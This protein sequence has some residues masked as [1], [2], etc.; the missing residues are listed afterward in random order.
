VILLEGKKVV[1]KKEEKLK[2]ISNEYVNKYN[3]RPCL[4][5]FSSTDN[6]ASLAYVNRIEK[7]CAKFNIDVIKYKY[8]NFEKFKKE[9]DF[10]NS[11]KNVTAIMFQEPLLDEL[12]CFVERI[13][14][15]KDVEGITFKNYGKLFLDKPDKIIPCTVKAVED[16]LEFYNIE[17]SEKKVVMLG[18]SNIVGKPLAV[19]LLNKSATVSVCHSKTKNIKKETKTA[20]ILIVAIGKEKYIKSDYIKDGAVVIDVGI[21]FDVNGKMVG[22]VDFDDVKNKS[23]AITPVPGGV[24]TVT[25]YSLIENIFKCFKS[26]NE[27]N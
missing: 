12:K 3:K 4:A 18:R 7:H 1:E 27:N 13:N 26:Q 11:S 25:N 15:R 2:K 10:A 6:E 23:Y 20:D 14:E 5:I 19:E 17:V 21:N 24:G 16:I 8:D 9:I 22:D